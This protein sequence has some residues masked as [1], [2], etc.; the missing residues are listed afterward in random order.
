MPTAK[1]TALATPAIANILAQLGD[2]ADKFEPENAALRHWLVERGANLQVRAHLQNPTPLALRVLRSIGRLQPV[3]GA[4]IS[5][6]MHT[7]KGSISK[8]ARRLMAEGLVQAETLPNNK[9]EVLFRLTPL[10]REVND[11]HSEFDA[12]MERGLVRFLERYHPDELLF[13]TRLLDD[14]LASDF[15]ALGAERGRR[16][17]R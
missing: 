12:Q 11:L 9:K 10:G 7:P 8:I 4:T 1:K 2:V 5:K 17:A 6:D 3:N 16:P 13:V 14:L 15:L